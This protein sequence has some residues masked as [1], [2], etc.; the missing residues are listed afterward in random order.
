[1]TEVILPQILAELI[2]PQILT[3]LT[4]PQIL[5]G[6][7]QPQTLTELILIQPQAPSELIQPQTLSE[8]IQPRTPERS[9]SASNSKMP[10]P[11]VR[12]ADFEKRHADCTLSIALPGFKSAKAIP[13]FPQA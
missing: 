4:Q 9:N 13:E 6:L 11:P 3:E 1:M 7:S 5:A 12:I 8:F 10:Y 2:Q